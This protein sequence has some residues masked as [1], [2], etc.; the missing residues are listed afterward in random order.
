MLQHLKLCKSDSSYQLNDYGDVLYYLVKSFKPRTVVE[1][2]SYQGY[3]AIHILSALSEQSYNS[4]FTSIDLY[5]KY[6]YEHSTQKVVLNNLK[7]NHLLNLS[8]VK[9]NLI[10]DDAINYADK[11]QDNSVDFLHIDINNNGD[12]LERCF[13]KWHK[14]MKLSSLILFEGGSEERDYVDWMIRRKKSHIRN[15]INSSFFKYNYKHI[16]LEPFP[17]MTIAMK[18][19][20][21]SYYSCL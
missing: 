21:K 17:S 7:K 11:F 20:S 6:I 12:S 4:S 13:N 1:L 16:I 15:F 3:S 2:G 9:L 10:Q 5:E 14:K 8:N 18:K 19:R